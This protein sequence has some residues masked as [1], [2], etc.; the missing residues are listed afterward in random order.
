[1]N[2]A[3]PLLALAFWS[4]AA[5]QFGPPQTLAESTGPLD[6]A[7]VDL[8][9]DGDLDLL[10]AGSAPRVVWYENLGAG[11]VG[12]LHILT[13]EAQEGEDLFAADLDGDA[14]VDLLIAAGWPHCISSIENRGPGVFGE[15]RHIEETYNSRGVFAADLDA[16]GYNDLLLAAGNEITWHENLATRTPVGDVY[17]APS[18]PNSSGQPGLLVPRPR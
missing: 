16:D 6:A 12:P 9:G 15:Q 8:D 2:P 11:S 18:I 3:S 7:I 10:S 17:C 1:M 14:D 4:P 13:T 5:A